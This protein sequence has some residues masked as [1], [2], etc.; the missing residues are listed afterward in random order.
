MDF[1]NPFSNAKSPQEKKEV[2]ICPSIYI[3]PRLGNFGFGI[4]RVNVAEGRR[5]IVGRHR[6]G[7]G[8]HQ[9]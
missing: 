3:S 8:R 4:P 2:C 9:A 1:S 6:T 7:R 5:G